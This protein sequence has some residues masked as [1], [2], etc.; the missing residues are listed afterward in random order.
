[1][2]ALNDRSKAMKGAKVLMLGVAYKKDIDDV[3]ESPALELFELLRERGAQVVYHD[4]HIP[5]VGRGRH[6]D[7][8]Q[9]SVALDERTIAEQD[10]VLIVTDHSK[11][12]Y[13]KVCKHAKLV[14]DTRNATKDLRR[15]FEDKI[16]RA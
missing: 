6:Y 12:D 10:L 7:L 14:V 5:H 3:R 16:V 4:P 2:M 11:V 13:A 15:Q 9:D 8:N 1:M